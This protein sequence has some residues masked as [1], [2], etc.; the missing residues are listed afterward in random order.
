M[1]FF[2]WH[3]KTET[4]RQK[5]RLTTRQETEMGARNF[6]SFVVSLALLYVLFVSV[7]FARD[8]FATCATI[9]AT[10]W[11]AEWLMQS[12]RKHLFHG[13][14]SPDG[15][16]VFITGMLADGLILYLAFLD[17]E[18]KI[19]VLLIMPVLVDAWRIA[20]QARLRRRR[21]EGLPCKWA[22][23]RPTLINDPS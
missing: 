23:I 12:V 3:S 18:V 4:Y 2:H 17:C 14:V 20:S 19:F 6:F 21:R 7:P 9:F 15:K 22:P 16:A 11:M 13:A 5:A 1:I 8:V 10:V